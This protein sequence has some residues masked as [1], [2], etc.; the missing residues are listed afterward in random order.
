M[1]P[2]DIRLRQDSVSIQFELFIICLALYTY[3]GHVK[4]DTICLM[5]MTYLGFADNDPLATTT[6]AADDE[7]VD[8]ADEDEE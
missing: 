5:L 3:L 6:A 7:V 8:E 2:K 4:T 1:A